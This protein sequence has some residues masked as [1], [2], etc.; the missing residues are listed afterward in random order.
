MAESASAQCLIRTDR[1][2]EEPFAVSDGDSS[3]T[4]K[5]SCFTEVDKAPGQFSRFGSLFGVP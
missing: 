1:G 4:A 2:V 5:G 3:C